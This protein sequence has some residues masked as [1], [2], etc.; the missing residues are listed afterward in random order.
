MH[1]CNDYRREVQLQKLHRIKFLKHPLLTSLFICFFAVQTTFSQASKLSVLALEMNDEL[2]R[3]EPT[4]IRFLIKE[5]REEIGDRY[6]DYDAAV[7]HRLAGTY[8][9]K[10][11][12]LNKSIYHLRLALQHFVAHEDFSL[13]SRIANDIGN[14]CQIAGYLDRSESYY[15]LSQDLASN[16]PDVEDKYISLYNYGRLK[17]ILGDTTEAVAMLSLYKEKVTELRKNESLADVLSTFYMIYEARGLKDSAMYFLNQ[18]I[19]AARNSGSKLSESNAVLNSAIYHFNQGDYYLALEQFHEGL[20]LRKIMKNRHLECDA[21]YDIGVYHFTLE[22]LDS[23]RFYFDQSLDLA[24]ENDLFQ[25]ARDA[26][27]ALL[28]LPLSEKERNTYSGEEQMIEAL[29][30]EHGK[31]DATDLNFK[32]INRT[33]KTENWQLGFV[34]LTAILLSI[35]GLKKLRVS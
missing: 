30:R 2:A 12:N 19:I 4:Q 27:E 13:S 24:L 10:S 21:L 16:S 29:I 5:I 1:K 17:L 33:K 32:Q 28:K 34:M 15:L 7:L 8:F 14:V 23:A 9:Q 31:E 20:A 35:A 22:H 26:I 18:A 6:T 3:S 25:D 11:G